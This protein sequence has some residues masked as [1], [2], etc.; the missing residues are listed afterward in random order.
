M[1]RCIY[2]LILTNTF[3]TF[4]SQDTLRI[5]EVSADNSDENDGRTEL[6]RDIEGADNIMT[7]SKLHVLLVIH[8]SC[9]Y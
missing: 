4:S 6:V 8:F 2:C 1:G 5:E 7:K 3:C 9:K